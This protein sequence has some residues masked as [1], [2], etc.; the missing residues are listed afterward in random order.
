MKRIEKPWGYEELLEHNEH[1]IVKRLFMKEDCCC[2]L[3]Y[4]EEKHET[5]Y[6]LSGT[7]RLVYGDTLEDI[8]DIV[9]GSGETYAIAPG[10]IHRMCGATDCLYLESSTN[11]LDDVVRLEDDYGRK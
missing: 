2:S 4:H 8:C 1:Y 10:K 6:V 3:Q 9:L 5:I 11:Q 7:M